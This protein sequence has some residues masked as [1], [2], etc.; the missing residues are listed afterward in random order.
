M[1]HIITK[2]LSAIWL[3]L[4]VITTSG[5][6]SLIDTYDK[7]AYH[8]ATS[9]KVESLALMDK[10]TSAYADNRQSVE[11][12]KVKVDKAYEYS[13]GRP[14]NEIVTKQ[15]KLMKDPTRNLLGGFLKRWEEK[16]TFTKVF[17]TEAKK[18]VS[19]GF[20][21]IIGLESGKIKPEGSE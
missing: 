16:G 21:Q 5:C 9:L 18:N 6:A 19:L 3:T 1:N 17:I 10:A 4:I 20:D 8:N 12:L 7:V 15:W 13:N 2:R 11:D 14:K